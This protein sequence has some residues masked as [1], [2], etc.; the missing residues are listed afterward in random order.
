LLWLR[1]QFEHAD[2]SEDLSEGVPPLSVDLVISRVSELACI[3]IPHLMV[4]IDA[5]AEVIVQ[6]HEVNIGVSEQRIQ[7]ANYEEFLL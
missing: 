1:L 4:I 5:P 3:Q 6:L 2:K 7:G